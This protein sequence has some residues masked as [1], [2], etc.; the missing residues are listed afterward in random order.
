MSIGFASERLAQQTLLYGECCSAKE[1]S[2]LEIDAATNRLS[3]AGS[4][5][6]RIKS[7]LR[8]LNTA[9]MDAEKAVQ[10]ALHGVHVV[11][12]Q[13]ELLLLVSFLYDLCHRVSSS[14]F[15]QNDAPL[16]WKGDLKA[17]SE[18][19]CEGDVYV[20]IVGLMKAGKSS[21]ISGLVGCDVVPSRATAMTVLPTVITHVVGQR[22]ARL[23]LP[24]AAVEAL[25]AVLATVSEK[26]CSPEF[27]HSTHNK[28]L[29]NIVNK[30]LEG[31]VSFDTNPVE[32]AD[33]IRAVLVDVN[34]IVR[35][36]EHIITD[37]ISPLEALGGLR[38]LP[39]IEIEFDC[40]PNIPFG[41]LSLVDSPGPNEFGMDGLGDVVKSTLRQAS[42]ISVVLN[43]TM[44]GSSEQVSDTQ[45]M[46]RQSNANWY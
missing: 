13:K 34:D 30:I 10:A 44:L 17:I 21:T 37:G 25:R 33:A 28:P 40:M 46:F 20:G 27:E 11:E 8:R 7:R 43:Y 1:A 5:E 4:N 18:D 12:H 38:D 45:A 16:R 32:G 24:A 35:L 15:M 31:T 6:K 29:D 42:I 23:V 2:V 3:E 19:V 39:H 26:V 14:Q 41:R 9:L 22:V 36:Y